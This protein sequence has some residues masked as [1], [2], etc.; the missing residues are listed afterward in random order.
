M[1]VVRLCNNHVA[2]TKEFNGSERCNNNF[3]FVH[4][5]TNW[6]NNLF[7]VYFVSFY[8]FRAYL[9]GLAIQPGQQRVI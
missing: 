5:K 6:V 1:T 2:V 8:V 3:L 4:R 7:L 9:V